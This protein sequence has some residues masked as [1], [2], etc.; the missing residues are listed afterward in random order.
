MLLETSISFS[1][2][3][4]GPLSMDLLY[5]HGDGDAAIL[6]LCGWAVLLLALTTP[7]PSIRRGPPSA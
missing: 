1:A 5:R 2:G 6:A 4:R 3:W 7:S